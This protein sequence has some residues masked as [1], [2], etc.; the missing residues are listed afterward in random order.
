[1]GAD[2]LVGTRQRFAGLTGALP[3]L[4]WPARCRRC[5]SAYSSAS[6]SAGAAS[7]RPQAISAGSSRRARHREG[8]GG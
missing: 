2:V 5:T 3:S 8:V 4:V 1:M 6:A 7:H